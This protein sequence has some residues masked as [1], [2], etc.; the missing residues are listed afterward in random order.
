MTSSRL[1]SGVISMSGADA[2]FID[3]ARPLQGLI[4]HALLQQSFN[5]WNGFGMFDQNSKVKNRVAMEPQLWVR[6][7]ISS[8]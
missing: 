4:S 2:R 3:A 6:T 1:R 5:R 7:V 8:S